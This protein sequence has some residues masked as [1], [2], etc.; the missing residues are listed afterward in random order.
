MVVEIDPMPNEIV[1]AVPFPDDTAP[2]TDEPSHALAFWHV[3]V[4]AQRVSRPIPSRFPRQGEPRALLLGQPRSRRHSFLGRAA[5][6]HPGGVPN[7]PLDVAR[8]AYSHEVTSCGFWPGN[9]ESPEPIFYAYAYPSPDGFAQASVPPEM[10]SGSRPSASSCSPMK[11]SA[12]PTNPTTHSWRSSRVRTRPPPTWRDGIE[13]GSNAPTRSA[14]TGGTTVLDPDHGAPAYFG[15][16]IRTPDQRLRVFVSSTLQELANERVAA[17]EA[18]TS[19]RLVPVLFSWAHARTPRDL[20]RAYLEQSHVFVGLYWQRYG[21][22]APDVDISGLEDE[23][24][25]AAEHP[26]LV[27]IK[28]PAPDREPRLTAL[29]DR[30]RR[31][32]HHVVPAVLQPPRAARADRER[33]RHP[34]E[35][36]LRGHRTRRRTSRTRAARY[37]SSRCPLHRRR[38]SAASSSSPRSAS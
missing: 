38:S 26:K 10:P 14:P 37:S 25:L 31:R 27:Y 30:I 9:A 3:L 5:P 32:E 8:E 33:P 15:P 13:T 29:I 34:L 2:R 1:D 16:V 19:L 11:P 24:I 23:A 35:R 20:Y 12:T 4:Q 6:D 18:I 21:W 17:Q 22:V 28:V 7:L 36:A